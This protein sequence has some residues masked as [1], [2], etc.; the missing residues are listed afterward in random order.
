MG[1][2]KKLLEEQRF[3]QE[4][5]ITAIL[6]CRVE[7]PVRVLGRTLNCL[8]R[9]PVCKTQLAVLKELRRA[10]NTAGLYGSGLPGVFLVPLSA[11]YKWDPA[12]LKLAAQCLRWLSV[13]EP[14]EEC[15][16]RL[17]CG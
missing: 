15:G 6:T 5:N 2:S 17:T 12:E 10:H 4:H 7:R 1:E 8:T 13:K 14:H 11:V 3:W 9:G 16:F